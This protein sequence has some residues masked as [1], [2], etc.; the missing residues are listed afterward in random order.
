MEVFQT[1][2]K[3]TLQNLSVTWCPPSGFTN[4]DTSHLSLPSH[5]SPGLI[6]NKMSILTKVSNTSSN[7]DTS[8]F[9]SSVTITGSFQKQQAKEAIQCTISSVPEKDYTE[10]T[11]AMLQ[12]S[13]WYQ[14][15]VLEEKLLQPQ[16]QREEI[17]EDDNGSPPAKKPCINGI[18]QSDH[19]A[20]REELVK[21][22]LMSGVP[23]FPY[24]YFQSLS[25]S[26]LVQILPWNES[27]PLA[28][29]NDPNLLSVY[30]P[31]RKRPRSK[32]SSTAV[33][34]MLPS[35]S[36][37]FTSF[38]E[39]TASAINSI[40][41]ASVN[42]VSFGLVNLDN[43]A[44]MEIGGHRIEDQEYYQKQADYM[45]WDKDGQLILPKCYYISEGGNENLAANNDKPQLPFKEDTTSDFKNVS[46][47]QQHLPGFDYKISPD[48][49]LEDCSLQAYYIPL[50]QMQLPSGAWSLS[51]ALAAVINV[52]LTDIL[53]LPVSNGHSSH[54]S[55]D[56]GKNQGHG[57]ATALALAFLQFHY[58]SLKLEW[59]LIAYK[60]NQWLI[61]NKD[62]IPLPISEVNKTSLQLITH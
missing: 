13:A 9:D 61:S 4:T 32:V 34:S 42:V 26:S 53:Q 39:R 11:I 24:T 27:K 25:S 37:S 56:S 35:L 52:P 50:I 7:N 51:P 10:A 12:H 15:S 62:C 36:F 2:L 45:H 17:L 29:Q 28:V 6:C 48:M 46:E 30:V 40:V 41:K 43:D 21:I 18:I 22:S 1:C 60:A 14:M 58:S 16:H 31:I 23:C 8:S 5:L 3:P 44:S 19:D 33:P 54:Y 59:N 38:A 57:W 55:S 20:I 49:K 47:Q